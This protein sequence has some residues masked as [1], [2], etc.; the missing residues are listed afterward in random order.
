MFEGN[1]CR[2]PTNT[3]RAVHHHPRQRTDHPARTLALFS[4]SPQAKH[5]VPS[6]GQC[7]NTRVPDSTVRSS[8][9]Q[10]ATARTAHLS[11]DGMADLKTQR[12][13]R[14]AGE[15][16]LV[17]KI[18]ASSKIPNSSPELSPS[19][20]AL[21][22]RGGVLRGS[23]N[24][25]GRRL[26]TMGCVASLAPMPEPLW[27]RTLSYPTQSACP[28]C[29]PLKIKNSKK[30][31]D[32]ICHTKFVRCPPKDV[33]GRARTDFRK[34]KEKQGRTAQVKPSI[35]EFPPPGR[36]AATR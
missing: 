3:T 33:Q 21:K 7:Q 16:Q 17:Y 27:V 20:A 35:Q 1:G 18:T 5:C 29:L 6:S 9:S 32:M 31:A 24:M 19:V 13:E 23:S 10:R 11:Q 4:E 14:A 15:H 22:N 34:K 26:S 28:T 8:S 30:N 25:L 36:S 12:R 2:E